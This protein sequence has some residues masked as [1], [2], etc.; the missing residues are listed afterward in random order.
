V[1]GIATRS[2][3]ESVAAASKPVL[4]RSTLSKESPSRGSPRL[5]SWLDAKD[6]DRKKWKVNTALV[7]TRFRSTAA[8]SGRSPRAGVLTGAD[9]SGRE[10]PGIPLVLNPAVYFDFWIRQ[11]KPVL[12]DFRALLQNLPAAFDSP[13]LKLEVAQS[14]ERGNGAELNRS[15][16][17]NLKLM[18]NRVHAISLYRSQ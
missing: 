15:R 9:R 11:A 10:Q 12:L 1:N 5:S 7:A 2:V 13:D 8:M 6:D 4:G 16:V 18:E 17:L 14:D 3:S